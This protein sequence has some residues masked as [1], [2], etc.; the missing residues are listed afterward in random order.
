MKL[1]RTNKKNVYLVGLNDILNMGRTSAALR[2]PKC[3]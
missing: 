3:A 1:G 2:R